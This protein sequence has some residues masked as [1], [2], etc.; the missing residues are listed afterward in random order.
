MKKTLLIEM[1]PDESETKIV[2]KSKN[3]LLQEQ[4]IDLIVLAYQ[5]SSKTEKVQTNDSDELIND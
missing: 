2:M 5:F 3:V 1:Q 4:V